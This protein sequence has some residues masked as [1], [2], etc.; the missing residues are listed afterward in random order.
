MG[1]RTVGVQQ[2]Y[3][4]TLPSLELFSGYR[5]SAADLVSCVGNDKGKEKESGGSRLRHLDGGPTLQEPSPLG[6]RT[7][8]RDFLLR[9][10]PRRGVGR[11]QTRRLEGGE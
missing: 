2:D 8:R 11:V 10:V 7:N 5:V 6:V 3:S 9:D 4:P 1:E